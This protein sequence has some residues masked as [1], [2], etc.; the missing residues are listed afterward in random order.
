MTRIEIEVRNPLLAISLMLVS[1]IPI[2]GLLIIF[3]GTTD[4]SGL[5]QFWWLMI[6]MAL[7]C[8]AFL[9]MIVR[10]FL[11][12]LRG[13]YIIEYNDQCFRGTKVGVGWT[14][15]REFVWGEING[16]GFLAQTGL[17]TK[18]SLSIEARRDQYLFGSELR[19]E[20]QIRLGKTLYEFHEKIKTNHEST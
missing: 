4:R 9:V 6:L 5:R 11:F 12:S 10:W 3:A 17:G 15:S 13:K 14:K 1:I 20:D 18:G 16:I 8:T 2:G 7:G 19:Y